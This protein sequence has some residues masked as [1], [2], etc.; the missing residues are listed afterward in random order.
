MEDRGR[1]SGTPR[2]SF[3]PAAKAGGGVKGGGNGNKQGRM[4]MWICRK[5]QISSI[6]KPQVVNRLYREDGIGESD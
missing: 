2:K 4:V 6:L 5:R 3:F 1:R